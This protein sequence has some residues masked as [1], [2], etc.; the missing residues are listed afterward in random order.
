MAA[1]VP[2][3]ENKGASSNKTTYLVASDDGTWHYSPTVAESPEEAVRNSEPESETQAQLD[4]SYAVYEL[5]SPTP[6]VIDTKVA[7]VRH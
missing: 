3:N 4:V 6:T 2:R 1:R 5:V 7:L